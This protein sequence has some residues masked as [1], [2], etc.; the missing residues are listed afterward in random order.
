MKKLLGVVVLLA[1]AGL[2]LAGSGGLGGGPW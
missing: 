1:L 2:A